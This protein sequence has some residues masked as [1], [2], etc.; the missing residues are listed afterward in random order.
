[1]RKLFFTKEHKE[2]EEESDLLKDFLNEST[3]WD[4]CTENDGPDWVVILEMENIDESK[5]YCVEI[6]TGL[7]LDFNG[8]GKHY[9]FRFKTLA[10]VFT[11]SMEYNAEPFN[12]TYFVEAL[13]YINK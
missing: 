9:Q 7:G 5:W 12:E 2:L 4:I 13:Q 6:C 11:W 3:Y 1:M 8:V 10:D